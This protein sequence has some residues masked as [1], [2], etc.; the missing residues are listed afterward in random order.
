M[1]DEPR[2][3][4]G[5]GMPGTTQDCLLCP[6]CLMIYAVRQT[7][8][9]VMEHVTKA[10]VELFQAFRAFAETAAEKLDKHDGLQRI[11]IN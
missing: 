5:F 11:P 1:D 9:E 10:G 2:A 3:S 7:R 4:G 8:P 6:F